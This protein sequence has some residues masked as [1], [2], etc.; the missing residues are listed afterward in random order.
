MLS[1]MTRRRFLAGL[2]A[3]G[4]ASRLPPALAS[5]G[6][7]PITRSIPSSGEVL[8]VI[9]MGTWRTFNVG[10]DPGLLD[11]R[12]RVLEVFFERGGRVVDSSPMYGSSEAVMG[13]LLARL[14]R[15]E[16]LFA[17]SKVW[18]RDEDETRESVQRSADLWGVGRFDLMQ[19]HNLLGWEGHLETL[20]A[21]KA[22]GE[23][24]HVGVTTSHG[25]RHDE[26]ERIMA[27]E[28]LDFVQLTYNLLDR[29]AEA[30]LL[31]LARERGIAVI[32]NRPFQGG[33]LFE[34]CQP[35]PLPGWAEDAGV[36]SWA[37]F[38]LKFIVSHPALTCAIP[39]TTRVEHMQENMGALHGRLPDEAQRRR[40]A[41]YVASL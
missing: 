3:A 36:S 9:G 2:A 6:D 28:P 1:S 7:S 24:R 16:A 11:Q 27:R 10:T 40:M 18:T 38:F 29:D 39:A 14:G 34:R 30:R 8:P 33:R 17:A 4:L 25:R 21:M 13:R 23:L 15:R 37:E 20:K 12:A 31:P 26:L 41:D 19:V 35:H 5:A 22:A 32:A